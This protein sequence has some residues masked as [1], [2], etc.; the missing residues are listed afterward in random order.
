MV[1]GREILRDS[2]LRDYVCSEI[3]SLIFFFAYMGR[4]WRLRTGVG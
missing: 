1:V 3:F 4:Y 2:I